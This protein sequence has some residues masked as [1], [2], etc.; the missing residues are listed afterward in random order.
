MGSAACLKLAVQ[1][2]NGAEQLFRLIHELVGGTQPSRIVLLS[3]GLAIRN[4]Q[5]ALGGDPARPTGA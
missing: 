1:V 5:G 3:E 4:E 2:V